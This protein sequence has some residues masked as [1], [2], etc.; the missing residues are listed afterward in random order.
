[1]NKNNLKQSPK[2]SPNEIIQSLKPH[3]PFAFDLFENFKATLAMQFPGNENNRGSFCSINGLRFEDMLDQVIYVALRCE[4][5]CTPYFIKECIL[6]SELLM[7]AM[8]NRGT[9]VTQ[10]EGEKD[11]LFSSNPSAT[12]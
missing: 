3:M 8:L 9:G 1:M 5:I 12:L 11:Y 2:P 10:F 4:I 6:D 7:S